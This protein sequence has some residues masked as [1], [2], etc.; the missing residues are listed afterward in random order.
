[1]SKLQRTDFEVGNRKLNSAAPSVLKDAK[2]F[3]RMRRYI[4]IL[5][6][7]VVP[8]SAAAIFVVFSAD[9]N[10]PVDSNSVSST[11]V[12]GSLG[13]A[14]AL[15]A[16]QNWLA[17][18]PAPLPGAVVVSW[19]GFSEEDPPAPKS[20][21]DI[22]PTYR[23]EIHSFTLRLGSTL[24]A[25]QVEVHTDELLGSKV[26]GKPTLMPLLPSDESGWTKEV[27]WFGFAEKS[28][29]EPVNGAIETWAKAFISGDPAVLRQAVGDPDAA[30]GYVP[31]SGAQSVTATITGAGSR[32]VDQ[33]EQ[34]ESW[35]LVRVELGVVWNGMTLGEREKATPIT[36]DVL[37]VDAETASPRVVSWGG[38]GS[39]PSLS[40]YSVARSGV[41][42]KVAEPTAPATPAPTAKEP[43][44][45]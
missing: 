38:P 21:T 9:Q 2:K 19:D 35:I 30:N 7:F 18:E 26:S 23:V 1:M 22:A 17:S 32:I 15:I 42:V 44:L 14:A 5:S 41:D 10:A 40:K 20:E 43:T 4:W 16:M 39:G 29:P 6:C 34:P 36:Y 24:F 11:D 8:L 27:T 31:L 37:V 28:A 13:K 25:S 45:G 12:N 33:G 3:K